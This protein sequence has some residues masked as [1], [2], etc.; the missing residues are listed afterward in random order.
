MTSITDDYMYEMLA[1]TKEYS[2]LILKPGPKANT[3][4]IKKII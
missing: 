4:D 1:K 3:E 2:I